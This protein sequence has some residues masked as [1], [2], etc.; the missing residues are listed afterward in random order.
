MPHIFMCL[1]LRETPTSSPIV[2]FTESL[3]GIS[4]DQVEVRATFLASSADRVSCFSSTSLRSSHQLGL[5]ALGPQLKGRSQESSYLSSSYKTVADF[6]YQRPVSCFEGC[7]GRGR[8]V[9]SWAVSK[10]RVVYS[11]IEE[12]HQLGTS[13]K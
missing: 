12:N 11:S 9:A 2:P 7:L 13:F 4:S 5:S 8:L 10:M 3:T 6:S 1:E